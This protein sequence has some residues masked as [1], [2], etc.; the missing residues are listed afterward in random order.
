VNSFCNESFK[1]IALTYGTTPY[2]FDDLFHM[3]KIKSG[4]KADEKAV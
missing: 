4:E 1:N 3:Q 2:E